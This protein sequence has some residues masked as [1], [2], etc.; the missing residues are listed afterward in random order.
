M[1]A[2]S[3]E[4]RLF[5]DS[6]TEPVPSED[7]VAF[8]YCDYD[9]PFWVRPNTRPGRW[10]R[11]GDGPTQ[12]WSLTPEGAWAE[13][14]RYEALTTE[15]DLDQVRMP[16]W[17]C[18][19]ASRGIVDFRRA[20]ARERYNLTQDNI[21]SDDWTTCQRAGAEVRQGFR[22]VITPSAA[23]PG[24]TNLTLFGARRVIAFERVPAL[25]SAVPG[26]VVAVGRPPRGLVQRVQLR[27]M[28]PTLF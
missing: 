5:H 16:I 20:T 1:A 12:Y 17:V 25:A 11:V 13:L 21:T 22:G 6:Q 3:E 9:V 15:A 19:V 18:R 27:T 2:D 26:A 8:R 7:L 28:Y 10:H 14:I 23:L 4:S 24:A